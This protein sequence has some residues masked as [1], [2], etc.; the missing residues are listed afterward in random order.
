[1]RNILIISISEFKSYFGFSGS[2]LVSSAFLLVSGYGFCWSPETYLQT[3]IQGFLSWAGF[4]LLFWAP[5]VTMRLLSEEEKLGTLELVMTAPV[6]EYEVIAGK[7]LAA[8]GI[9]TVMLVI[10]LVYPL[11]LEWFGDP[12]WGP[13][14][15][16]YIGI[17]LLGAVFLSVGLFA[18]SLTSNQIVAFILG[19]I[20]LLA[21]WFIGKTVAMVES[22]IGDILSIISVSA[23]YPDFGRGIIDSR[24]VIY[25][26]SLVMVFLFLAVRSLETRRLR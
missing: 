12:D 2:Y 15:S 20:T 18:S 13:I 10:T 3:T 7:Y 6:K 9:F 25:Y 16:G 17:F 4:F 22:G 14:V 19:S 26:L 8:L 24:A 5:A 23:Y 1:M 21:F 11:L